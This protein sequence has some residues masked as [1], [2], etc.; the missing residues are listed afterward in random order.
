[1]AISFLASESVDNSIEFGGDNSLENYA[2][3]TMVGQGLQVAV[4]DPADTTNPLVDFDGAYER[5]LIGSTTVANT[6]YLRVGGAGNQ[7]SRIELTETT[8]G[9]GKVMNYGF[10]FNQTGS[11]SNTLEIKRHSN[12]TA[13]STVMTLARDNSNVTFAGDLTVSGGDITLGGTGRIQGIDTVSA[14][15]DAANKAYV[16][17]AVSGVSSGVT[18]VATT[19]GI[20]GGTITST[21]TIQVDSTVVRTTGTQTVGGAKTFSSAVDISTSGGEMLRLTDTNSIGDAATAYISFDDSAGTRQGY[22]GIG[23]VGSATLY[24]E[25]LDGIVALNPFSV[26]GNLATSGDLTVSGGDIILGG[27]G[28]IQGVDTVSDSTDAVNKAYVDAKSV[29]ILTLASANGITVT[30]GTTANATVGV[31]YTAASNNLVHPAT[32][33]TNLNQGTSYGTYFL[34]ADSNPGITYGAVSKIRTGYMR[35]NDFGAPD[36]SINMNAQKITN[37]ATPTATT[38]AANKAYVDANSGVTGTGSNTRVA[39][40]SGTS[41]LTSD[42]QLIFDTSTNKLTSNLFQIPNNGDYLGTDTGGSARTL[43]SLTSGNDVEVS[44]SALSSGSD[45]NIYFGDSFRVRDGGNTRLSINSTGLMSNLG[46]TFESGPIK[47][48]EGYKIT[49]DYDADSWNWIQAINGSMEMAVGGG[50]TLTNVEENLFGDIIVNSLYRIITSGVTT[51]A[52]YIPIY[53]DSAS[54]TVPR[55]QRTQTPAQFLSNAGAITGSGTSGR[56][57]FFT[58]TRTQS[59]DTLYW[60]SSNNVL[61]INYSGTTFNSGALQIQG[62]ISSGGIG[63][64]IYNYTTGSSYGAVGLYVN[65]PRYGNGGIV[66]KNGNVGTTFMRFYSSSGSTVG[67]ITQNGT[68]STSYNTSSDYRLKKNI[69][70]M[71]GS[72]D[73]LKKLKPSNFNFID[74]DVSRGATITVDGFIAHEVSDIIPEAITG[75]KDG[76]DYKGDPEYQSIDQS[77]IVPLLTSALQEAIAKIESLEARLKVLES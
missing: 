11:V 37:V 50:L 25:G 18:S 63:V 31:N 44:N 29:G 20:T 56:V 54:S 14:S 10:S 13:G 45:T 34:C 53:T 38:D 72:I 42:A 46:N 32:T 57:A 36:G 9:V 48:E 68:S 73:R 5:V 69:I 67:T 15:T 75:E 64:Q 66:I 1:M 2:T 65:A 59:S 33:I 35:L 74:Q 3:L 28:R 58:G 19:N 4:G 26:D 51:N 6:P 17:S 39:F 77:K 70:P 41:S 7:S 30:G 49:F 24:L 23:S 16:D 55:F 22:V 21:G 71:T 47:L 62:P 60:S 12:S 8:T 40:W 43:I 52:T 76:V 27:T 61:G